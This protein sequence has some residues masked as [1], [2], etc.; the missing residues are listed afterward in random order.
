MNKGFKLMGLLA[1]SAAVAISGCGKS[2]DDETKS[3]PG[4]SPSASAS[5]ATSAA[6]SKAAPAPIRMFVSDQALPQ[7][8]AGDPNIA[9]LEEK[10]N[11][12]LDM[13]YLPHAQYDDQLKL[14]FASGDFPDAYQ[15]WTGPDPDLIKAGKIL[16]LND[17][18]D[19]YGPNLKEKIPQAAW[20]AVSLN[21]QI[22][23]I[24][25]PSDQSNSVMYIRK[26]WLDKLG[27]AVP[28]TS[29]ELLDVLRAF[30]DKDP[31]GNGKADEIPLSMREKMTWGDNFFGMWGVNNAWTETYYNNEVI[32]DN[33]HPNM[34]TALAYVHQLVEEK[35]IDSEFLT[36]SKS[37][38]EQ[39][40]KSGL[41]GVW[42]H[43]QSLAWQWQSDLTATVPNENPSVIAIPTPRGA[44]YDGPLGT[45][46]S[47][48]GKT[49]IVTKDAKNPQAI[50]QYFDW[51][52]SDEGQLLTDLG[53][54]GDTYKQE[55][56]K[57][58]VDAEKVKG[59]N[60]FTAIFKIHGT[61]EAV[62][63][64]KL[65]NPDA[66]AKLKLAREVGSKEGFV[67]EAVG[68]PSTSDYNINTM[69]LEAA[70][71]IVLGKAPIDS[72]DQFVKDWRAQG[73]DKMIQERTAWYNENRKK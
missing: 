35:L 32:L 36:N 64:A 67:N 23:A 33:I 14:K 4:N 71:K 10:T 17:L 70:S 50:I 49:Y 5:A 72:F 37:V 43:V 9:Y 29:D 11:T 38:W 42:S 28:T 26:D 54:E 12:K 46:W 65:N 27:L 44:G 34:K 73:G 41:V 58:V 16:P 55:G 21:G 60:T 8:A 48:V 15:S 6:P 13:V 1:I 7:L 19:Q 51:L 22:L 40:I 3:T 2:G 31:N 39:K 68:M 57:L 24:P 56:G 47:P 61:N 59:L 53:R 30:R 63:E 45:R 69:F 18:I 25:Q 52:M 20:D 66:Y 62:E